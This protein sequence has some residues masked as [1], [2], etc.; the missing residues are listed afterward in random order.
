M[1]QK[2]TPQDKVQNIRL[3]LQQLYIFS[4]SHP[5]I[6]DDIEY[7]FINLPTTTKVTPFHR[8]KEGDPWIL[9]LFDRYK[10][11]LLKRLYLADWEFVKLISYQQ[12]F[13]EHL[14]M[15]DIHY[16][17]HYNILW[18]D[19]LYTDMYVPRIL[20]KFECQRHL[21]LRKWIV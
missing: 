14:N 9:K 6:L 5:E 10:N 12:F 4:Q 8:I 13:V 17:T 21:Y 11:T 19:I 15:V 7:F 2:I 16:Q 18:N 3:F 20:K 1:T